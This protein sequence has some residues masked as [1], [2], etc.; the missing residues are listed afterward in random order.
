[1]SKTIQLDM[2]EVTR[3]IRLIS[4]K[5]GTGLAR[6]GGGVILLR[7]LALISKERFETGGFGK[8]PPLSPSTVR[9][10]AGR[11]GH[12]KQ[13]PAAGV[14]AAGPVL[15]WSGRLRASLADPR[16]RGLRDSVARLSRARMTWGTRTPYARFLA[17][18]KKSPRY[19]LLD[20]DAKQERRLVGALE[21]WIG[22]D[23]E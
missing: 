16:G 7:E 11:W 5:V 17:G 1:M 21:D 19:R 20:I 2:A 6:H 14:T 15:V 12:Y 9:A 8:W 4:E 23:L 18:D 13:Q 10:R 3:T 22:E